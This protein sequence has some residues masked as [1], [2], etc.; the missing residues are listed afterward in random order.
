LAICLVVVKPETVI[1][2]HRRAFGCSGPGKSV[3]ANS[4][5]HQCPKKF[6]QLIRKMSREN[7]LWGG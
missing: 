7:P 2:C 5:V 6:R 3:V 4:G 1:G